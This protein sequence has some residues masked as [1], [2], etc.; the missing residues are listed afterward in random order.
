[1]ALGKGI[2]GEPFIFDLRKAPHL[3]VAGSTGSGK[4]VSLNAMI[5]GLLYRSTPREV[6]MLM[7][8]PKRL[9]LSVYEGIPHLLHPV[10]ADPKDAAL[11]LKWAVAEMERRYILLAAQ[12]VRHIDS[13]NRLVAKNN[14]K[15]RKK[16]K[17]PVLEE[18]SQGDTIPLP[19]AAN[20][21]EPT[22]RPEPPDEPLPLILIIID[23]LAD[24]MMV[25]AREIEESICRLAQMA[26]AAG[27][28]LILAT[29]RPSVDVITGL[30]KANFPS[31]IG[32]KVASKTDSRTILDQNGSERL[33]GQG[34]MLFLAPGTSNLVRLHGAFV[35]DQEIKLVTE[36]WRE[37][38]EPDYAEEI[39][40][41]RPG[42]K[43]EEAEEAD[44]K[45]EEALRIVVTTRQASISMLQ[46]K[47]KIGYNRAARIIERMETDGYVGPSDGVKSREVLLDPMQLE[48]MT[49][50]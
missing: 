11:S 29:Q 38:G 20:G 28:H 13:Y 19:R 1:M 43:V 45:Y 34:D 39:L 44:E 17:P 22:S 41:P 4:S 8:D 47:L 24:L 5:M 33:L 37:Q 32:F 14:G 26:R 21:S 7:I 27:I 2:T 35:S 40:L 18:L 12:G 30:I 6:R 36:F 9:E 3:L 25:A 16:K 49:G 10:I 46:R 42:D 50:S 15:D 31:R 23:E 48:Q